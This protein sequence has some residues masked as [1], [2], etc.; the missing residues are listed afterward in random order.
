MTLNSFKSSAWT[1]AMKN[2]ADPAR[3]K[4]RLQLLADTD[5]AAE[6]A[7]ASAEQARVLAALLSGSNALSERLAKSAD[8]LPNLSPEDLSH[9][10]SKPRLTREI[11]SWLEDLLAAG[12]YPAALR[13]LREF[14]ERETIRIA[15]RDLAR[16]SNVPEITRELSDLA[17]VCLDGVWSVCMR[18]LTA[19]YGSPWYRDPEGKWVAMR[20]CVLGM[21]KLGGQE[22]N[23]SS[24]VD[25][26]FAYAEEGYVFKEPPRRSQQAGSGMTAHQLFNRVAESFIAEVSRTTPEGTL[27]RID[28]RLR[29]EGDSG[30][31]SRSLPSYENYYAQWGQTWERMML[32][33]ARPVAGDLAVGGEFLEM[34]QPFRYPAQSTRRCFAKLPP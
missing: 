31:L 4:R 19:R 11:E 15:A 5:A 7:G 10:H 27:Y 9:P 3:V 26:I 21:G 34:I 14:K 33:K 22:L 30:P 18:Q 2:A 29:P 1:R 23:Y 6:L 13:K 20:G 17:D 12:D 24:D 32:I 25:V 28:L 8:L 16:M